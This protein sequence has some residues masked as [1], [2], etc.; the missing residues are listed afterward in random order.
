MVDNSFFEESREQSLIKATIVS[1]YFWA[2]AKVIIGAMRKRPE[3]SRDKLAYVD[4]F[5]GPGRYKDGSASTPILVLK[6][7]IED[8]DIRERLVTIFNDK[9]EGNKR[10]LETEIKRISNLHL[11]K[12]Q[13]QVLNEEVGDKIVQNLEQAK[14]VPT[15]YFVDPWGYK[16]LSLRLVNS[17]LKDWGCDCIFFFNYNRISMGLSN[18]FV[19]EHM[20]ALFGQERADDLRNRLEG[21]KPFERE[22]T[23]VNELTL[24]LKELGGEY[25]LPFCFKNERGVRTSHHLIF[26]SKHVRGYEIMK[27]IMAEYSSNKDQGVPSFEYNPADERYALL[28][29]LTSPLDELLRMLPE[30]FAGKTISMKQIYEEHHVGKPYIKRNYKEVLVRLEKEGKIVASPPAEKRRRRNGKV[31]FGDSVKVT[32]PTPKD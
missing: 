26:V 2:W 14:L 19:V 25:V 20:N 24:A 4:L 27:E 7:A 29:E 31:T 16:G 13:P 3:F 9:N 1:K 6:K 11:L 28:F 23:I 32:F 17:V 21:M 30:D 15:L 18:P 10:S 12:H 5:A 8:R 22:M